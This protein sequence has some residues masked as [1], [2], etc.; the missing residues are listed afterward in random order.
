MAK[1]VSIGKYPPLEGGISA[2]SYWL[3][4]ALAVRGHAIHLVTDSLNT[5]ERHSIQLA[6]PIPCHEN[7]SIHRPEETVPW[8][9][10]DDRE[11]VLYLLD[12]VL[13]V[14]GTVTPDVIEANYLVPYGVVAFLAG[15]LTGIPYVLRHGGSDVRK[16]LEGGLWP[17]LWRKVL[18]GARLVIT[19]V[20][21]RETVDG[22]SDHTRCLVPYV[23]DPS[24]FRPLPRRNARRV[25]ALIGKANYH[26]ER[27]GWQHVADMWPF[28]GKEYNLVVVSQGL[29]LESFRHYAEPRLGDRAAWRSFVAPW[30]MPELLNSLDGI[31]CYDADLPFP[32]FSN[33]AVEALNCDVTVFADRPDTLQR[34]Q[35]HG[36]DL[37]LRAEQIVSLPAVDPA[38]AARVLMDHFASRS[39]QP[40]PVNPKLFDQYVSS[41][42]EALV[43]SN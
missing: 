26:W 22:W 6:G 1:I 34:F 7:V 19:D 15:R 20:D 28:L 12:K 30:E 24:V 41:Y 10:P 27:K 33:L 42:E 18:G 31:F 17:E 9:I 39:N 40:V 36:L 3:A 13:E 23:P 11:R 14:A 8:H 38:R 43:D 16:F 21:C 29:G 4:N 25:L 32:A 37:S 2:K 5:D 35:A